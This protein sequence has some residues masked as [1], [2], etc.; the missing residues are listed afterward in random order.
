MA[1]YDGKDRNSFSGSLE[2]LPSSLDMEDSEGDQLEPEVPGKKPL[3]LSFDQDL[4]RGEVYPMRNL[5]RPIPPMSH[6]GGI[7]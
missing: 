2:D 6:R 1:H 7:S 4:E 3:H 5:L